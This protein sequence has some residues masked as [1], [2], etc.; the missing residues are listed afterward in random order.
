MQLSRKTGI[1]CAPLPFHSV[2][3]WDESHQKQSI[4]EAAKDPN[5]FPPEI[6]AI[7]VAGEE[8][9]ATPEQT[10]TRCQAAQKNRGGITV[11]S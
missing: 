1:F 6:A 8:A 11:C 4:R 9:G 3:K 5:Y 10:R 2:A 7:R